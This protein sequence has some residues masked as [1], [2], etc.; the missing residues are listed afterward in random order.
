[1]QDVYDAMGY[2][3]AVPDEPTAQLTMQLLEEVGQVITPAYTFTFVEGAPAH[4][5]VT[6]GGVE[7]ETGRSI[8]KALVGA[9]RFAVFLVTA[10]AGFDQWSEQVRS[11][12]D[13]MCEFVADAIGSA[14]AGSVGKYVS[15]QVS[16]LLTEV[17]TT[18]HFSPG[19][20]D[21]HISEQTKVFS[22]L[23]ENTCGVSL[24]SSSL[25]HPI[26]SIT[27]IIGIGK[28][29]RSAVNSCSLCPLTGCFRRNT[30]AGHSL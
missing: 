3:G 7:F 10:G 15:M 16:K 30:S 20:C 1:M 27:G 4:H 28:T 5:T 19:H 23:G 22:L 18:N 11:R 25:M 8:A 9:D 21:W 14:L 2:R 26:K 6:V 12:G 13:I 17:N 24:S 29:V